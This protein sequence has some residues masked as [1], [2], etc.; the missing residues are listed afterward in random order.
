MI[1]KHA[2]SSKEFLLSSSF[3]YFWFPLQIESN[4]AVVGSFNLSLS[5]IVVVCFILVLQEHLHETKRVGKD[6]ESDMKIAA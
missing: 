1:S 3:L 5:V 4:N 2:V 6:C